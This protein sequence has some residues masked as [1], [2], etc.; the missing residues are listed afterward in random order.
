VILLLAIVAGLVAGLGRAWYRQGRLAAPVL[1]YVWLVPLAFWPQWLAFFLPATRRSV[2]DGLATACLVG[3]QVLLLAF[4]ALNWN[5]PGFRALALGLALNLL[6][7]AA[8]GGLMPMSPETLAEL[9]PEYAGVAG[10]RIGVSKNVLLPAAA[11]WLSWLSDRFLTPAWFPYRV[12]FSLGDALIAA[13]AFWVLWAAGGRA[14]EKI[15][16]RRSSRDAT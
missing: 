10:D 1:G 11:T 2:S 3:S 12:A 15:D 5:K 14:H 4:G 9:T 8:N 6:V 7:I 16:S 13:G